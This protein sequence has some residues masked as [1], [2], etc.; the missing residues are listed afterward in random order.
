M[1]CIGQHRLGRLLQPRL[2]AHVWLFCRGH[3]DSPLPALRR[4]R[5][6]GFRLSGRA[7][8]EKFL[9][10]IDAR[11]PSHSPAAHQR[12]S[13]TSRQQIGDGQEDLLARPRRRLCQ[14][15]G[16][17]GL[18]ARQHDAPRT[19]AGRAE[20]VAK[21]HGRSATLHRE[22]G[23]RGQRPIA[24]QFVEDNEG[25]E[26]RCHQRHRRR[27]SGGRKHHRAI[28][29]PG[30][31]PAPL[32]GDRGLIATKQPA[33]VDSHG[34]ASLRRLEPEHRQAPCRTVPDAT[35]ITKAPRLWLL[36]GTVPGQCR[37]RCRGRS[38]GSSR[39][40]GRSRS[41][42]GRPRRSHGQE[43]ERQIP[44]HAVGHD[45]EF[46]D[47]FG[48]FDLRVF[49]EQPF[50]PLGRRLPVA[51]HQSIGRHRRDRIEQAQALGKRGDLLGDRRRLPHLPRRDTIV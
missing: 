39:R 24:R 43:L 22:Q 26:K 13:A 5:S 31:L 18:E 3:L 16:H 4:R 25:V 23:P 17:G 36:V 32:L 30:E 34:T 47:A 7:I 8:P 49:K 48:Q 35:D 29:R 50:D 51:C 12:R 14:P 10:E 1:P 33:G 44:E 37:D 2:A 42:A 45:H 11:L 15:A 6:L 40:P 41:A 19:L 28:D 21:R 9:H 38:L 27:W 46:V 20:P